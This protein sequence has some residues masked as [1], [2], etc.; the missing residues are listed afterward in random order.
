[1]YMNLHIIVYSQNLETKNWVIY[2][3]IPLSHKMGINY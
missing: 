3:Q 2:Y 1:M